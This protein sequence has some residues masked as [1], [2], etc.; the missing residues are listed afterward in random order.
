MANIRYF[1]DY[2]RNR[3]YP[4]PDAPNEDTS[5]NGRT[6]ALHMLDAEEQLKLRSSNLT[7]C[8]QLAHT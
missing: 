8:L 7:Y 3:H 2:L 6:S 1:E 5:G 4:L